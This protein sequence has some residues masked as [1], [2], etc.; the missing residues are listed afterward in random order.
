MGAE[1]SLLAG[2]LVEILWRFVRPRK[3]GWIMPPDGAVRLFP[4]LVRIPDVSFIRRDRVPDGKFPKVPLLTVV[5]DL[6]IE[7]L[8]PGN[9]KSEM[10]RKLRDY[11]LAGIPLVWF[12]NPPKR[13]AEV[14]TSPEKKKEVGVNE[15]LDGGDVL[16][17]FW[18][19]LKELF[20]L[21]EE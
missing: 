21:A 10:K 4:Q 8:S 6:A 12:I 5:P 1:E 20:D 2:I 17:G 9:T 16:P 13:T 3:L 14:Y 15:A 7:V 19:P 18:L 11:F